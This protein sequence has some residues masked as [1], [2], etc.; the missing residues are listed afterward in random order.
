MISPR[1][2]EELLLTHNQQKLRDKNFISINYAC[3]Q[4]ILLH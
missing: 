2:T 1:L 4:I 3:T